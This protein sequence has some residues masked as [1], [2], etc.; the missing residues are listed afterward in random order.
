[1]HVKGGELYHCVNVADSNLAT[2]LVVSV[3]NLKVNELNT[4]MTE[5]FQ[6]MLLN[7]HFLLFI[8]HCYYDSTCSYQASL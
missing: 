3:I 4:N 8:S 6:I 2:K 7:D 1:M 5:N